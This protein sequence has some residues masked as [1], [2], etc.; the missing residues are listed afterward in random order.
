MCGGIARHWPRSY[1]RRRAG[2]YWPRQDGSSR[3][4]R[5]G[6]SLP[7]RVVRWT[8]PTTSNQTFLRLDQLLSH[9][10]ALT[11][12][13][14]DER[15]TLAAPRGFILT[16]SIWAIVAA[17]RD[18]D[19]TLLQAVERGDGSSLHGASTLGSLRQTLPKLD[20]GRGLFPMGGFINYCLMYLGVDRTSQ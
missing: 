10:A 19:L 3:P 8:W 5:A 12:Q 2:S 9:C 4:R 7:R 17:P 15:L 14:G 1:C 20:L 11:A 18:S 6:S 13:A 16:A